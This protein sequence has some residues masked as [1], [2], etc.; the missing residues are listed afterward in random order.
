MTV[1]FQREE[2]ETCFEDIKV[3][4]KEAWAEVGHGGLQNRTPAPD[5]EMYKRLAEKKMVFA[6]T[7]REEGVLVGYCSVF[8]TDLIQHQGVKQAFCDSLYLRKE[9]RG[10]L[11]MVFLKEVVVIAKAAGA[12]NMDFH[13]TIKKN[14][15]KVLEKIG[16]S[17]TSFTY[18]ME[19]KDA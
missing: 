4:A 5:S 13:V 12:A 6:V 7:A 16:F 11:G 9:N 17:L 3:L 18:S 2:Y 15:G 19:L 10:R 8:L 14:F 1:V